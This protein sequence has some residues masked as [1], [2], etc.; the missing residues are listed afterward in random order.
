MTGSDMWFIGW[1]GEDDLGGGQTDPLFMGPDT[2]VRS[3]LGSLIQ[4]DIPK[5][6][7]CSLL[8]QTSSA[9]DS[10]PCP[11]LLSALRKQAERMRKGGI[12]PVGQSASMADECWTGSIVLPTNLLDGSWSEVKAHLKYLYCILGLWQRLHL[13]KQKREL[14]WNQYAECLWAMEEGNVLFFFGC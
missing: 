9:Q 7:L 14:I 8:S 13:T 6:K 5:R 4:K 1:Y 12:I 10:S 11:F 2:S 3:L